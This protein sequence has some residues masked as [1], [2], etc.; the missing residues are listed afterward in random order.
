MVREVEGIIVSETPYGESS[1]IIN[2]LTS[3]GEIIGAM[4]KGAKKIKSTLRVGTEKLTFGNFNIYY[5]KDKLSTLV[6][7]DILNPLLNIKTDIVKIGY[8][9][10]IV[11]LAYQTAKQS[12][13][14]NVYK[15]L[16]STILKMESGLNPRIMTNILELKML[17]YLGVGIDLDKCI[18][19][20]STKNILTISGDEGGYICHECH[21]NEPI[22]NEK[23]IKM[24]RLYYYVDID[25]ITDLKIS[26][27]VVGNIDEILKDYYDRFTGLYLKSKEFLKSVAD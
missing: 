25:T 26:D 16:K 20:G 11:E 13:D 22:Y 5:H 8:L 2:I 23:T 24:F 19:C 4:A 21:T 10:Y 14:E 27:E 15:I 3:N 9:T 18:K 1:K 7:A 6:S 12:G 17:D